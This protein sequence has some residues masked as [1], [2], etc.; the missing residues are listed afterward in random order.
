M[1]IEQA[2]L[3]SIEHARQL[4]EERRKEL[5][6]VVNAYCYI[7]DNNMEGSSS[8][9]YFLYDITAHYR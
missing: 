2:R 7:I 5:E 8:E 3:D 6:D 4:E 9:G 1:S